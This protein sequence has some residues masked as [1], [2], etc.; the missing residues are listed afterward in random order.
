MRKKIL[1]CLIFLFRRN[2]GL[3][4]NRET[5]QQH[6]E[7]LIW[8]SQPRSKEIVEISTKAGQNLTI[9][10]PINTSWSFPN[11]TNREVDGYDFDEFQKRFYIEETEENTQ[12]TINDLQPTD[13]GLYQCA[14]SGNFSELGSSSPLSFYVFVKGSNL[15]LKPKRKEIYL[16]T[17]SRRNIIIPCRTTAPIDVTKMKLFVDDEQWFGLCTDTRAVQTVL[18]NNVL[19]NLGTQHKDIFD[20]MPTFAYYSARDGFNFGTLKTPFQVKQIDEKR[21]RCEYETSSV[22]L[23]SVEFSALVRD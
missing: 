10:C 22:K 15:F 19:I 11:H 8:E 4:R 5:E 18:D 21:F 14:D 12:L 3:S 6:L 23:E 2:H 16:T 13:T 7:R 17:G 1:F 20:C 9:T